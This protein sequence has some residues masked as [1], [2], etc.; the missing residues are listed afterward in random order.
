MAIHIL[1]HSHFPCPCTLNLHIVE[2][3]HNEIRRNQT[4]PTESYI[5]SVMHTH[6][7]Y[8]YII[9]ANDTLIF[10]D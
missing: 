3:R 4:R 7:T 5:P 2:R 10:S 6:P 1:K 9:L 8:T